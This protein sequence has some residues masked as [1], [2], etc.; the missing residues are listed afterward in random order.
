MMGAALIVLTLVSV[1][2]LQAQE[3]AGT[4]SRAAEVRIDVANVKHWMAG[5]VGASWHAIG[6]TA[7]SYQGLHDRANRNSRGSGWGG[8]P[9]LENTEAWNDINRLGRWLGMDFM[10]VEI[11]MRMYEP[12]HG[13]YVWQSKDMRTL[14][15]IL[16]YCQENHVDVFLTQMWQD[17]DWNA[18]EGAGR[19]QSAPESVAD[20]AKGLA[21]LMD[22]LVKTKHYDSIRWLCIVN[23]PGGDVELVAGSG[24]QAGHIDARPTRR[25][26]G[27]GQ[28]RHRCRSLGT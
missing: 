25:S 11:D 1:Q 28:A 9:P 14:Y 27:V 21:T 10:R 16:D 17:V 24:R 4:I 12:R 5:G 23:E 19:L 8:N 26:R 7:F 20:F 22:Y 2:N 3:Q 15:R 18:F 6:P 13:E